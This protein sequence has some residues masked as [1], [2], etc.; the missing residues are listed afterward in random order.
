[1]AKAELIEFWSFDDMQTEDYVLAEEYVL[2]IDDLQRKL[3]TMMP[4]ELDSSHEFLINLESP[5][6]KSINAGGYVLEGES[7][8]IPFF[9][10]YLE[11]KTGYIV[12]DKADRPV[13]YGNLFGRLQALHGVDKFDPNILISRL[14][15]FYLGEIDTLQEVFNY[16]VSLAGK[17]TFNDKS[18]LY[19][20]LCNTDK[21]ESSKFKFKGMMEY[22]KTLYNLDHA[23]KMLVA[24]GAPTVMEDYQEG[25]YSINADPEIF[26]RY[27]YNLDNEKVKDFYDTLDSLRD[28]SILDSVTEDIF[29]QEI[30]VNSTK[31]KLS[32][33]ENRYFR[34]LPL[35]EAS[36]DDEM[37][38]YATLLG[39]KQEI[40][41]SIKSSKFKDVIK[42]A[43][44]K[45]VITKKDSILSRVANFKAVDNTQS[46]TFKLQKGFITLLKYYRVFDS[47]VVK[48][49]L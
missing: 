40:I 29:N 22:L 1:M 28:E 9:G 37:K 11:T 15:Q 20:L 36:E 21:I 3:A 31:E 35:I 38:C 45:G 23:F 18:Y 46:I 32:K 49:V 25:K 47:K 14:E 39:E 4:E 43:F 10:L 6:S 41:D 5:G 24:C 17:A 7:T 30:V 33:S 8:I 48:R 27:M 42:G 26:M 12:S 16:S 13:I 2:K 34:M 44:L 19:N